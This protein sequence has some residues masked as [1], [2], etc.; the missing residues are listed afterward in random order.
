MKSNKLRR[1]EITA[2]RLHKQEKAHRAEVEVRRAEITADTAPFNPSL[3]A[4]YNSYGQPTF[5]RDGY[6]RD[7]NF[8]CVDCGIE[9]V[10][11]A[12]QQKWWY[13]VAKGHVESRATRCHRCRKIETE[14]R[15][16]ARR[17]HLDGLA[18]KRQDQTPP[19][20]GDDSD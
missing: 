13:E 7:A 20:P 2:T 1:A 18:R 9:E 11:R 8:T 14:R 19:P 3:L 6:Y 10:W 15:N 12:T 17:V 5:V 16:Q 4:P